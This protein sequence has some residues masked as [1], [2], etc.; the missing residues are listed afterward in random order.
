MIT[1]RE[2]IDSIID[3]APEILQ[4]DKHHAPMLFVFGEADNAIVLLEFTDADSKHAS[5]L[6][7]GKRVRFLYPYCVALVSEAWISKTIPPKGKAVHDMA[8]KEECL[9]VAAQNEEGE[10]ESA[11]VPFSRVVGEVLLG[12]TMYAP[13]AEAYLLRLFWKG[14]GEGGDK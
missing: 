8:D 4:Q 6:A 5:M 12:E 9:L 13:H 11:M 2:A 7:A 3:K 14:V 1:P 10:T